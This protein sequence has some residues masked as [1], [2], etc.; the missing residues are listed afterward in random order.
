MCSHSLSNREEPY[1][2]D[3]FDAPGVN[4]AKSIMR[5]PHDL[6]NRKAAY[7]RLF[8]LSRMPAGPEEW[9]LYQ[10]W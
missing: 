10:I 5:F 7:E 8:E 2:V 1:V 9:S 6:T 4:R 3:T